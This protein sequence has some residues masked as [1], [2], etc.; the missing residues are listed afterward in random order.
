MLGAADDAME[1]LPEPSAVTHSIVAAGTHA[2][3]ASAELPMF[4]SAQGRSPCSARMVDSALPLPST[5]T[6]YRAF[7]TSEHEIPAMAL[8]S[9]SLDDQVDGVGV[10]L[11]GN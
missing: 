1:T 10:P 4:T 7:D 9:G 8:A 2:M 6:Q 5:A 3:D 11:V